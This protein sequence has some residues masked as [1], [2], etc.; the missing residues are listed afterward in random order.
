V[1]CRVP[2]RR[3]ATLSAPDLVVRS[4]LFLISAS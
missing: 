1:A 2:V 4:F 3:P